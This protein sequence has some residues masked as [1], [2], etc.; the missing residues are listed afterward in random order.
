MIEE[1]N[2][3]TRG[4]NDKSYAPV[5]TRFRLP[6]LDEDPVLDIESVGN[7]IGD[8]KA[9]ARGYKGNPTICMQSLTSIE[10]VNT[11]TCISQHAGI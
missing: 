7:Y 6:T 11:Y 2:P 3:V 1:R 4:S 9:M 8:R 5:L 10:H